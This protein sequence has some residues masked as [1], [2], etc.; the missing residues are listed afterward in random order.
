M[1]RAKHCGF[2]ELLA[3]LALNLARRQHAAP[4]QQLPY[5]GDQRRD[6]IGARCA[7]CAL[8]VA[9][10]AQRVDKWQRLGAHQK[11]GMIARRAKQVERKRRLRFNQPRQQLLRA[12]NRAAWRRRVGLTQTGLDER[13]SWCGNLRL[14]RKKKGEA[15]LREPRLRVVESH[16][17]L[18]LLPPE[19]RARCQ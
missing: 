18:G 9:V 10:A 1:Q 13:R 3:Q 4:L 17:R 12:L 8:P 2:G 6:A 14:A 5:M 11:I 15:G 19:R 16:K 7:R